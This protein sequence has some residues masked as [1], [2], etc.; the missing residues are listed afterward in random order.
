VTRVDHQHDLSTA[1]RLRAAT[2]RRR[3]RL[4][5]A[6][7]IGVTVLAAC[8]SS[9]PARPT[10]PSA[11]SSAA[12]VGGGTSSAMSSPPAS[13]TAATSRPAAA[14]AVVTIDKFAYSTRFTA[15]MK[16]GSYPFH[17]AY[18]SNMHGVLVVR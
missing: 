3:I 16:P 9:A 5:L 1:A 18:H 14:A 10:T 8:G 4:G 2:W 17:C 13:S 6:G 15:P 11:V 12:S 7:A